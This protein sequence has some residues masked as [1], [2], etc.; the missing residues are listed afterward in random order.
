MYLR[1]DS[2]VRHAAHLLASRVAEH[3]VHRR[4]EL[5]ALGI[6]DSLQSAMIRRHVLTRLRHGV[7]A[8]SD[9]IQT[10]DPVG[11]HRM[12]LAAAA[13]SAREPIW[14]FGLSAALLY[15]MPTPV[16]VPTILH[17]VR[18]SGL[19]ERALVKPSRHR[20]TIPQTRIAT[21]RVQE[22]A[23]RVI[24][25][26]PVVG[27][28]L[29]AVSSAAELQSRRWR[30]ALMDAALWRGAT[31]DEI[32]D[33]IERWR[34]LGGRTELLA[35][36]DDTRVGAQTVL[37]TFSRLALLEQGLPEPVLQQSFH[38]ERGLIGYVDMWWP[39]L[40]VVGEADGALKYQQR[41]DLVN[42]K[43]REDR[44][45]AAGLGVVR[46]TSEEIQDDPA[47]VA[48]QI[49]RASRIARHR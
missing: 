40:Q 44:L 28:A 12:D 36:T 32:R 19:D 41:A 14:A 18:S 24:S 16:P 26:V 33:E 29:A 39:D 48:N 10:A 7:Y 31:M 45:R 37:E 20:L 21:G 8:L 6:P 35:A 22:S 46:W 30:I 23:C 25:G 5:I 2:D 17:L 47:R 3:P 4:D 43:K 13:V 49:R 11:R 42:E 34:H 9:L 15:D 1:L 38:D 27:P